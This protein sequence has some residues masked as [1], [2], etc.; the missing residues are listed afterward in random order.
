MSNLLEIPMKQIR[1][2]LVI[3]LGAAFSFS[4][5]ALTILTEQFQDY[6][7]GQ[8]GAVGTGG[9][10]QFAWNTARSHIVVT[11]GSGSL[12]GTAL[13]LVASA[14]DMVYILSTANTNDNFD[15]N[16]A[17]VPNGCYN[18]YVQKVPTNPNLNA[19][20]ASFNLY[21]SFLY[22]FNDN[23]NFPG[24]GVSMIAGMYLQSGGIQSGTPQGVD[25]YWQLL[26]RSAGGTNV[27]I[28]IAKNIFNNGVAPGITNWDNTLV[29]VGQT[30]FIV[31]RLQVA[32]TNGTAYYTNDEADLWINPPANTFGTNEANVPSPD[33]SSAPNDG[34][35][36]S[37]ATG[38]GRFF[39]VDNGPTANLDELRISTNGWADVTPPFGQCLSATNGFSTQPTNLTQVAEINASLVAKAPN[40]TAPAYQWQ[41]SKDGGT[42][43]NNIS[44]ANFNTYTTPNLQLATDNNNKYRAIITTPCD[45]LSATSAVS[46]ITLT[47]PTVTPSP[48]AIM[49]DTFPESSFRDVS[50]VTS[51]HSTWF[52]ASTLSAD[53]F[54][55]NTGAS[56]G[57]LVAI[58]VTNT[59]TLYLGYYVA[60]TASSKLPVHL[61]IGSQI[62]A[63]L[64]F[65]PNGYTYFTNNGSLRF[66][67]FDYADSGSL[68]T[69]DDPT[70][71]GS[72]GNG[73]NVRGYMLDLDFGKVFSTSN[74]L[75]LYVRTGLADNNLIGTTGDFASLANG[76][77]NGAYSNTTAFVSGTTYTLT[78]SVARTGTNNCTLTASITGGSLNLT[79]SG[80]DTNAL[81]YHRF[82]TIAVR[83]IRGENAPDQFNFTQLL[84]Q[85]ANAPTTASSV[86]LT[87]I[88]DVHLPVGTNNITTNSVTLTWQPTPTANASL[89]FVQ[90]KDNSLTDTW[91]TV[92]GQ[93]PSTVTNWTD[94]VTNPVSFYRVFGQ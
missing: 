32:A 54:T 10:G 91:S 52:T 45:G 86:A 12:D 43:W 46:T 31:T 72:L 2:I 18:L 92:V 47:A 82:D 67:L 78:L 44:G 42:T 6:A 49:N 70:L 65:T 64:Q 69:A 62:I 90:R 3:A 26:A 25:A 27:Q 14:G 8:L 71:T 9:S 37:S 58:P 88:K 87:S 55:D 21:T 7:T 30:F 80:A 89:F 34:A 23:T 22:R 33:V 84:V 66:G 79:C 24:N 56:G 5:S 68:Y 73:A 61:A 57:G 85:V 28:G 59:S 63:T 35:P 11:N 41:L 48:S 39:I 81:G 94:T 16:A 4:A 13:G 38:P 77:Y 83:P 51:T 74:P 93:L 60:E 29:G 40:T 17:G 15:T 76:P 36:P 75:S 50:P 53:L 20:N 19:T 1:L